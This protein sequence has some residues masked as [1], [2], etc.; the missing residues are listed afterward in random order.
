MVL[1]A[2]LTGVVVFTFGKRRF[3]RVEGVIFLAIYVAYT[4]YLL[5]RS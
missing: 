5:M 2:V 4:V 1:A 3:D